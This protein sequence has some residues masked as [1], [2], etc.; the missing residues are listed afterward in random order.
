MTLMEDKSG[1]YNLCILDVVRMDI[2]DR[3]ASL[4]L[5]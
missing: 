5:H 4:L 1:D 2:S 3:C